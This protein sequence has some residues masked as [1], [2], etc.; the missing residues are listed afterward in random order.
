MARQSAS[1]CGWKTEG[2]RSGPGASG[3]SGLWRSTLSR[4]KAWRYSPSII[5]CSAATPSRAWIAACIEGLEHNTRF[6]S[7][8]AAARLPPPS[9]ASARLYASLVG[10]LSPALAAVLK[11]AQAS[12]QPPK[13]RKRSPLASCTSARSGASVSASRRSSEALSASPSSLQQQPRMT[14]A[15]TLPAAAPP[16]PAFAASKRILVQTFTASRC[17]PSMQSTSASRKS[18]WAA[19]S[20]PTR[21]AERRAWSCRTSIASSVRPRP[22]RQEARRWPALSGTPVPA[23]FAC[24]STASRSCTA[25]ER[26][27]GERPASPWRAA[28]ARTIARWMRAS[29]LAGWMRTALVKQPMA[30]SNSLALDLMMPLAIIRVNCMASSLGSMAS[31]LRQSTAASSH[32]PRSQSARARR[33]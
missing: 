21:P 25:S 27:C 2:S 31:A 18:C 32:L 33:T 5:I 12:P 16:G 6:R 10:S 7:F 26:S 22:Q 20:G 3:P 4:T 17:R 11:A 30:A 13:E 19:A 8:C 24:C 28:L 23:M 29:V 1:S 9:R 14:K 15:S